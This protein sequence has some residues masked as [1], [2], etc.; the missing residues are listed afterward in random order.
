MPEE[1]L[2]SASPRQNNL[3]KVSRVMSVA[4]ASIARRCECNRLAELPSQG[5]SG[6]GNRQSFHG[7][8]LR[9]DWLAGV[10]IARQKLS[11]EGLNE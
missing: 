11:P 9:C 7:E 2:A 8:E 6:D 10:I 1:G 5:S 4:R 3:C